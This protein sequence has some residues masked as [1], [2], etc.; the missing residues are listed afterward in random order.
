MA[1]KAKKIELKISNQENFYLQNI[2]EEKNLKKKEKEIE[3]PE[4]K[5]FIVFKSEKAVDNV[6]INGEEIT[7]FCLILKIG[8]FIPFLYIKPNKE[9]INFISSSSNE[10]T[11][12]NKSLVNSEANEFYF[13]PYN[14][15]EIK[16]FI[17]KKILNSTT[18][19]K[20]ID[21]IKFS[22]KSSM[23]LNNTES[24]LLASFKKTEEM[25]LSLEIN[26]NYISFTE[27]INE[28]KKQ[29]ERRIE[30]S[31]KLEVLKVPKKEEVISI[32]KEKKEKDERRLPENQISEIVNESNDFSREIEKEIKEEKP[33]VVKKKKKVKEAD[34]KVGFYS[35]SNEEKNYSQF[36]TAK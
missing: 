5:D 20:F 28:K 27:N 1:I 36:Y 18:T 21:L 15:L 35:M 2:V 23:R 16:S 4:K 12:L 22:K 3:K 9:F 13:G 32:N 26:D 11:Q 30:E 25:I 34:I 24:F 10:I 29:I 6:E 33:I 14:L 17:K 31:K 8:N 19:A 7:N